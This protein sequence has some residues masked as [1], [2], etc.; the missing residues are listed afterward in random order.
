MGGRLSLTCLARSHSLRRRPDLQQL[1]E[2]NSSSVWPVALQACVTGSEVPSGPRCKHRSAERSR[3]LPSQV[4]SDS[5]F[6]HC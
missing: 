4:K 5:R 1:W 3:C 6:V 2:D